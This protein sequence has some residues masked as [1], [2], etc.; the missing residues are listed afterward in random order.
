MKLPVVVRHDDPPGGASPE[1]TAAPV[2]YGVDRSWSN[3]RANSDGHMAPSD[4]RKFHLDRGDSTAKC[5]SRVLLNSL[6]GDRGE[7]LADLE[8]NAPGAVC[9]RCVPRS[10]VLGSEQ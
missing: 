6:P 1:V 3:Y 9:R 4:H 7:P 2:V 8:R 10:T 5:S